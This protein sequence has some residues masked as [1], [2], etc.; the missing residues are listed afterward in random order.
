LE[1][2]KSMNRKFNYWLRSIGLIVLLWV[3]VCPLFGQLD[4]SVSYGPPALPVYD[5]PTCPA[6]G[7]AWTPGYWA[8]DPDYGYYWVPGTWVSAPQTGYLWTPPWWGWN[9]GSYIFHEGYWGT[10]VGFYGGINYGF[11]YYGNGFEGGRWQGNQFFYN[12]SVMNVNV[13]EIH[14]VYNTTIV[15]RVI[16]SRV[17]YNGGVGGLTARPTAAQ[18]AIETGRHL[19]PVATQ[20]QHRQQARSNPELRAS[21]N[22][23]KPPIAATVRP[24]S[25]SGRG[26][27]AARE[28][29][30]PYHARPNAKGTR[31]A[32]K[33]LEN[34]PRETPKG[35]KPAATVDRRPEGNPREAR[36]PKTQTREPS[37]TATEHRS[38]TATERRTTIATEHRS[39]TANRTSVT[40]PREE[41]AA[42]APTTA[43][44]H[45][46]A[47]ANRSS[48]TRRS[49][50]HAASARTE[51]QLGSGPVHA[52]E[53][54]RHEAPAA[55]P[56][57]S[58][59]EEK[60]HQQ[61]EKSAAKQNQEHQTLQRQQEGED[62]RAK[63]QNV[64]EKQQQQNE[65]RHQ[66]QTQ[67]MEQRHAA[68]TKH[69][70]EHPAPAK[71][72]NHETEKPH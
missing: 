45:R 63:Q 69:A 28:A 70:T 5:Q 25:F 68:Q 18:R 24:T 15:N 57:S 23:G 8:W 53:L 2:S 48:A 11:G 44:E 67:Q 59:Q 31:P 64:N 27:V 58:A 34:H 6:E 49:E 52:S 72:A 62:Q 1:G 47:T 61:Q 14:N 54:P 65:V 56:G 55:H 16:N 26:V 10:Q 3:L 21:A 17:S 39:A 35:S 50:E 36:P 30:G 60:A 42:S 9:E 41:R 37:T 43:T 19:S 13:T 33:A 22:R 38:T 29:G 66:Q 40:K 51:K 32:E 7:Y 20:V 71:P 4:I 12:R 46:S